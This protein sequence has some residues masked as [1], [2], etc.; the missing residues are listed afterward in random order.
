MGY[1]YFKDEE[2]IINDRSVKNS[3]ISLATCIDDMPSVRY[4]N[5]F[6]DNNAFYVLTNA[7]SNKIKHTAN[8][9]NVAI[10]EEWFT[11]SGKGENLGYFGREE[12]MAIANSPFWEIGF[13]GSE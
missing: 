10:A 13:T 8:N 7:L 4:V 5:A 6:Y 3:I 11:A 1:G 9:P 12:N 2:N